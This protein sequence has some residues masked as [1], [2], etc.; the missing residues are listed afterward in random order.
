MLKLMYQGNRCTCGV[1]AY[2]ILLSGL[3]IRISE[4][5]ACD[6][7]NCTK[8]GTNTLN[9]LRALNRRKIE[10]HLI[11][12][13][14]SFQSYQ[15]WLYL[16]SINRLLYV[17]MFG[18]NRGKKGKPTKENHAVCISMGMVYDSSIKEV[19]PIEAYETKYNFRFVIKEMILVDIPDKYRKKNVDNYE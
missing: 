1:C 10:A 12:L 4:R 7:V 5:V 11:D 6:E 2:S 16:N 19:L 9:V 8:N 14:I 13:D 15:R 17:S 3:G 18:Q